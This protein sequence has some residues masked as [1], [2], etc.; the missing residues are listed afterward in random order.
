MEGIEERLLWAPATIAW[1][2]RL[3]VVI[4][5]L[6]KKNLHFQ[7][8]KTDLLRSD[9]GGSSNYSLE[10]RVECRHQFFLEKEP[11]VNTFNKTKQIY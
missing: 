1:K 8:N 11:V 7:Q 6:L 2:K 9:S 10:E 3:N 5:F 4:N